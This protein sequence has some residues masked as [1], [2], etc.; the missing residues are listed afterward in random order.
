MNIADI[1]ILELLTQVY[2]SGGF[3]KP[4]EA[5]ALFEPSEV[6]KRGI[7]ICAHE[8]QFS[9]LAGMVIVVPPDSAYLRMA[10]KNEAELHLLGVKQEYQRQGL[11]RKLVEAAVES[12]TCSG[13]SKIILWTQLS[14]NSAQKLYESAGFLHIGNMERNGRDFKVYERTICS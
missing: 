9:K 8:K 10:G 7:L 4:V 13:Y 1:E 5:V 12:A 6:R 2:V 14:M 3:T 11:G